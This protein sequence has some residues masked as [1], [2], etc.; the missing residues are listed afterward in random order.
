MSSAL[1]IM[2]IDWSLF[3]GCH[4]S[5]QRGLLHTQDHMIVCKSKSMWLTN[6]LNH[7]YSLHCVVCTKGDMKIEIAKGLKMVYL[8]GG[9]F[10][11]MGFGLC[12]IFIMYISCM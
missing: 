3:F 12:V 2:L 9:L 5:Y 10:I 1:C 4:K 8:S 7:Y 6:Q 11:H